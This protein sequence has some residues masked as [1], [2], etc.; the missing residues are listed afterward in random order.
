MKADPSGPHCDISLNF[1]I[2]IGS[3]PLYVSLPTGPQFRP[4]LPIP[5]APPMIQND[6]TAAFGWVQPHPSNDPC[7]PY[8]KI[9]NIFT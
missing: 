3:V 2:T 8:G 4:D 5:T 1:P 6:Q 9:N 7:P